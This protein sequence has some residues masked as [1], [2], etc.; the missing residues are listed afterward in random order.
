VDCEKEVEVGAPRRLPLDPAFPRPPV[1][2][3]T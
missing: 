3:K 2:L 1:R